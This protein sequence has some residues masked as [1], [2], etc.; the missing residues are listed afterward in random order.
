MDV[1]T[2][3]LSPI[4]EQDIERLKREQNEWQTHIKE[5]MTTKQRDRATFQ[6]KD[7]TDTEVAGDIRKRAAD[8]ILELQSAP[9][10]TCVIVNH[11]GEG[12]LNWKRSPDGSFSDGEPCADA[13]ATVDALAAIL[14]GE[15]P[16]SRVVEYWEGI[17]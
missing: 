3:F 5:L 9:Q 2:V 10:Y 1:Q 14:H 11:D 13:K 16:Q 8:A 15:K 12:S 17:L 4:S 6:G 7:P